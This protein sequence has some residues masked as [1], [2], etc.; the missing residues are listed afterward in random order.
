VGR[1]PALDPGAGAAKGGA[2]KGPPAGAPKQ[3]AG[4]ASKSSQLIDAIN[5]AVAENKRKDSPYYN[6]LDTDQ[7]AVMGMSCGGIQTYAVATDPRIKLLGIWNSGILNTPPAG[8]APVMEDV[9]KDQLEKLHSPIFYV[10]GDKSDIAHENGMDD[11]KRLTKVSS[12]H[13]YRDGIGHGGTYSQPNGGEFA[14]VAVALLE[15]QLKGNK[16]SAKMFLGADCGL[17]Q[18]PNWHVSKKGY[19]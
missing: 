11:F 9:R 3:P 5:W 8:N 17:C 18:D 7:I 13:M 4:L 10:T 2:K 1:P 14:K 12:I 19:K 15:W 16:E 6:K